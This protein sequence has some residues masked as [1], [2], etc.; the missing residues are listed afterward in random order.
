MK[1][2]LISIFFFVLLFVFSCSN[3]I[4]AQN[5]ISENI[6]TKSNGRII[7][8]YKV[9]EDFLNSDKSWESYKKIVLEA[10]PEMQAVHNKTLSWGS[11]DSV[12][13]PEEVTK[14]KKADWEHYF[15]E[16][17]RK[18]LDYL[19]DSLIARA[20]M[21]LAPLNHNHV[22]LCLFLPYGGCF[23]IPGERKCTI[24]ISL[25][26]NPDEVPKIMIHEYAHN[27]HIQRRPVEPYNLRREIVSEGMA[28]YL[29]TLIL[30][31]PGLSKSVPFMPDSSVQWCFRNEQLIK[32][33]IKT[34][35]GDTTFNCLK[36]F[37]ADGPVSTPPK[38]F[39]EK[40][41]YF[42]GYRIIE[43]CIKKGMKLDD[44]CSLNSDS[45]LAESG[46]FN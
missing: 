12:R 5:N 38:G 43:A 33:T 13:F 27:L 26:I 14:F 1:K 20:N 3:D 19:Y 29:T 6:I 21:I 10:Y 36:K 44:I 23:I 42:A 11:I 4:T 39:V 15:S 34:E 45:V 31:D 40:T 41:G 30:K 32:T 16:Y 46:Y 2:T 7:L 24:Y 37:I 18:T 8:A 17:N 22:D 35:L 25:L 28:V 9:F